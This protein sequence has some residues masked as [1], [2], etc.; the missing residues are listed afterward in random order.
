MRRGFCTL[1]LF[2]YSGKSVVKILVVVVIVVVVSLDKRI[3]KT[4]QDT[5]VKLCM[6]NGIHD[7]LCKSILFFCKQFCLLVNN[8]K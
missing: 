5:G 2:I 7:R 4:R 1:V 3:S 6:M 8:K